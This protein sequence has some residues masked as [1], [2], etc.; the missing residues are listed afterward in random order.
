MFKLPIR[1]CLVLDDLIDRLIGEYITLKGLLFGFQI[2]FS[3]LALTI[4]SIRSMRPTGSKYNEENVS[5]LNNNTGKS[6]CLVDIRDKIFIV[7]IYQKLL[8]LV[9]IFCRKIE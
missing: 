2:F 9:F 7:S 8:Y 3:C 1:K 5:F 4:N 6:Y